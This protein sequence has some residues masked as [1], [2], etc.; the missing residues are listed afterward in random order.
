MYYKHLQIP[1][2]DSTFSRYSPGFYQ[3]SVLTQMRPFFGTRRESFSILVMILPFRGTRPDS[4]NFWYSQWFDPFPVLV[5]N[6]FRYSPEQF[7][8]TQT[9]STFSRYSPGFYYFSVRTQIRPFPVLDGTIFRYSYRFYLLPVLPRILPFFGTHTDSTLF[10]YSSG[11]F[12]DTRT[13]ST[14]SRYSSG[15]YHFSRSE[16]RRVGKECRSRWSPYH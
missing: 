12:F 8:D 7:F 4:T 9:D 10:R 13:D 14:F 2:T 6:V 15:F 1:R 3:F 11:Q 16:E 5:G